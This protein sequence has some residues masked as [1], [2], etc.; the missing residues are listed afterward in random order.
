M[1]NSKLGLTER[2][3]AS[4]SILVLGSALL[5]A[6]SSCNDPQV[7]T[8]STTDKFTVY[9]QDLY[10]QANAILQADYLFVMDYS[11]SSRYFR[12]PL[13]QNFG[14]FVSDLQYS[15]IQYQVAFTSGMI[16]STG[17]TSQISSSF[18]TPIITP[19]DSITGALQ[20]QIEGMGIPNSPNDGYFLE[21]AR[22]TLQNKASEFVRP[23]AQL[24]LVF[25]TDDEDQ[26]YKIDSV[27]N[28][29]KALTRHK[30]DKAYISARAMTAGA[31]STWVNDQ[32]IKCPLDGNLNQRSATMLHQAVPQ[33][34]GLGTKTLF[35]VNYAD[36]APQ[37]FLGNLAR[38]ISK[39]TSRFLIQGTP[40]PTT[41]TV[42]VKPAG[43]G[44]VPMVLGVDFVYQS[45]TNE[46]VFSPGREPPFNA[47]LE[48]NYQPIYPLSKNADPQSIE[49]RINGE[50]VAS[51][52]DN[53]WT[54]NMTQNRIV[55]HGTAIP[56]NGDQ[57]KITYQDI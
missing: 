52:P 7:Y 13:A 15:N 49:V 21:A 33:I 19:A 30:P 56:S 53:G 47:E 1:G 8:P 27:A 6:L 24:V 44:W 2:P 5:V 18:I 51:D 39:T 35:C 54:Y 17:S 12:R 38:N 45:S 48:I 26:S 22:R 3:I 42:R 20:A 43:G 41:M 16:Q 4:H 50:I 40:D 28:Y 9:N 23:N 55:F 37:E 29:V 32:K 14:N 36:G 11:L 57:V 46:I 34:D 10:S 25:I 31:D